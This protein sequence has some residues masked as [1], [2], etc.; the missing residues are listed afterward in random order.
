MTNKTPCILK[1]LLA[2]MTMTAMNLLMTKA[3]RIL[4]QALKSTSTTLTTLN[5]TA[6]TKICLSQGDLAVTTKVPLP[7]SSLTT[8]PHRTIIQAATDP[9]P[10]GATL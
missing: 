4:T 10:A 1:S 8:P 7:S 9:N 3:C 2:D 5:P 6:T